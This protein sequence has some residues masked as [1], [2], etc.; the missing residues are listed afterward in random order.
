MGAES[1]DVLDMIFRMEKAF[2]IKSPRGEVG[3]DAS[4]LFADSGMER[5]YEGMFDADDRHGGLTALGATK[6]REMNPDIKIISIEAGLCLADAITV[7]GLVA[8]VAK[9]L[10]G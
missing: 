1:I 4:C 8:Y 2:G 5:P 10:E 9:K 6:L 7:Q 3:I